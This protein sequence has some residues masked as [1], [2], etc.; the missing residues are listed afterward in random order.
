MQFNTLLTCKYICYYDL[1]YFIVVKNNMVGK[2]LRISGGDQIGTWI[3]A[4]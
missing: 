1:F 3:Q 4:G 2:M